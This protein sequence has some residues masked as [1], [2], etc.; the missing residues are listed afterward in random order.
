[1]SDITAAL[2]PEAGVGPGQANASTGANQPSIPS[3]AESD[4]AAA[5]TSPGT[6]PQPDLGS[7]RGV[8]WRAAIYCAD[9][10]RDERIRW[11]TFISQCVISLM[12]VGFAIAMLSKACYGPTS[13][14]LTIIT[15]ELMDC[16]CCCRR[17]GCC[18]HCCSC[19]FGW[20]AICPA[21]T[22]H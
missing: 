12:I 19:E 11:Y 7:Q 8:L 20:S 4:A 22:I 17:G 10:T 3:M 9:A 13:I 5:A 16:C 2:L 21:Q 18:C 1:M 6:E 15:G 14:Y